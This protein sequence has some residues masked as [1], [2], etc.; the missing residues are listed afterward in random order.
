MTDP[1]PIPTPEAAMACLRAILAGPMA[2]PR[3]AAFGPAARLGHDLGLDS[4]ALMTLMLHLDEQGIAM[5][6]DTFDRAPGLT[7]QQL[8]EALAGVTPAKT[9]DEDPID[10]KVHCVVSCLC[11]ALKDRGGI[12]HRPLYLGLWDGQVIIDD[13]MRLSYHAPD[14]DHGFYLHW[15]EQLF[16][17]QV[18]RWYD[19]AAPKAVNLDHLH[20]L[21]AGWRPGQYVMPMIDM[22]LL[23]QRD[24]KFAQDPFPHYALL[25]PTADPDTW[26][27]RDPDF[28]WE[29][30][31]PASDLRAAFLR[32]TVAGGFAFDSALAHPATPD[33]IARMYHATFDPQATPLIDGI[34][35]ILQAHV[36]DLP[37]ADLEPAL[38]ELPV[39]AIRKYAYE[40]ALAILGDIE[41][42]DHDAFEE[43]C[44]R[45]AALHGGLN[46][47]HLRAVAFARTGDGCDLMQALQ[48]LDRL[49]TLERGIKATLAQWFDRWQGA[50]A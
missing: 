45:I 13:R 5:A 47:V 11:Q 20:A 12:D 10:I 30:P 15:A 42:A 29:G 22:A 23:P 4:T 6:E 28:R 33:A 14:I 18:T 26:L 19:D 38:R 50:G 16:G 32:P 1:R 40:H 43:C 41:G 49:A 21:L 35:R 8:A 46:A 36:A 34:R 25:E 39:I 17:L 3:M 48:D 24:N 27:M 44:D 31:L 2:N 7:V 37:R 9:D